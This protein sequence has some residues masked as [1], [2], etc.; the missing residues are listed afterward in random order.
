MFLGS[1][2][3]LE[4]SACFTINETF[5]DFYEEPKILLEKFPFSIISISISLSIFI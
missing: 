2:N 4:K 1:D 3:S 5:Q